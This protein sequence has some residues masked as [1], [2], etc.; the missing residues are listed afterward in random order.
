MRKSTS[1]EFLNIRKENSGKVLAKQTKHGMDINKERIYRSISSPK[2]DPMVGCVP[3]HF[4]Y[5]ISWR[6]GPVDTILMGTPI[7]DS[8]NSTYFLAFSG[9][10]S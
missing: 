9:R 6:L 5:V 2:D 4:R 10:A 8:R 7:L 3:D 1:S